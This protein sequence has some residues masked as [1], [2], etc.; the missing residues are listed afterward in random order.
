MLGGGAGPI[1]ALPQA[2]NG[3]IAIGVTG[4]NP[5]LDTLT[6]GTG[7]IIKNTAGKI[8]ISSG[9]A[10]VNSQLAPNVSPGS[11]ATGATWTSGPLT[12]T[13][14]VLGNIVVGSIT[15]DLQGCMMTTYVSGNNQIHVSIFN[16]TGSPK[17]FGSNLTLKV[18][19]VQ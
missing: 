10:G 17:N 8:T 1:Q 6:A 5:V 19:V 13:G 18:L 11:I 7:I 4:G 2:I 12:I 16:G 14:V 3:Q 9:V 15:T